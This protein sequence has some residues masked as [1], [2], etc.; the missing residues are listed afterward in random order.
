MDILAIFRQYGVPFNDP[1]DPNYRGTCQCDFSAYVEDIFS[2]GALALCSQNFPAE[3]N[4]T[5][6]L[7]NICTNT[8]ADDD[9]RFSSGDSILDPIYHTGNVSIGTNANTHRLRVDGL[10]QFNPV[11]GS[12]FDF[13]SVFRFSQTANPRVSISLPSTPPLRSPLGSLLFQG[14]LSGNY[15]TGASILSESD[16]AWSTANTSGSLVFS[17]T[18]NNT[19]GALAA[20]TIQT[21]YR[22]R[23]NRYTTFEDGVPDRILGLTSGA[24]N[25]VSKHSITGIGTQGKV[26][27]V[28]SMGLEWLDGSSSVSVSNGLSSAGDIILGGPLT[29]DT[30]IEND[31][32]VF[33]LGLTSPGSGDYYGYIQHTGLSGQVRLQATRV[34]TGQTTYQLINHAIAQTRYT[35]GAIQASV[36][37]EATGVELQFQNGTAT[38]LRLLNNTIQLQGLPSYADDAAA[39][40]DVNLPVGGL[41]KTTGST[42]LKIK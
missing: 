8:G 19:T 15:V 36:T 27:G 7:Q 24:N 17:V 1:C 10:F 6:I 25:L 35:Q 33:S 41:Y 37:A 13:D 28:G 11:V 34:S 26:L 42:T 18:D 16:T 23:L 40:A 5:T 39:T 20:M 21:N 22:L 14:V 29:Q 32:H 31:A 30:D 12:V 2:Q 3:T 38:I 4:L 9:W